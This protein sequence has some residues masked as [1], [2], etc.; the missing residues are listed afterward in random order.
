MDFF[1]LSPVFTKCFVL[2]LNIPVG[3]DHMV[4]IS[5]LWTIVDKQLGFKF[6]ILVPDNFTTEQCTTTFDTHVVPT[7]GYLYCIVI[8]QETLFMLSYF[9]S[10]A[11]NKGIKLEPSTVYYPQTDVQLGIVN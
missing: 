11:A 5:Q 1:E 9:Q 10:S 2:Y 7:V 6:L 4:C 8:D 3:E